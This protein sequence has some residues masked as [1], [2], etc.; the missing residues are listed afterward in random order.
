MSK[1]IIS[2]VTSKSQTVIPKAI[3]THMGLKSGDYIRYVVKGDTVEI[4]RM[5]EKESLDPFSAFTEWSSDADEKA[6]AYLQPKH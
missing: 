4:E 6:F 5:G 3:R 2:T 1:N